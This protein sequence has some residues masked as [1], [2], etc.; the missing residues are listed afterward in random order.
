MRILNTVLFCALS[1]VSVPDAL[2]E[3]E[4]SDTAQEDGSFHPARIGLCGGYDPGCYGFGV[5]LEVSG[6]YF[7]TNVH[8]GL[9]WA[10]I[11]CKIYPGLS[12]HSE[13]LSLR[14]YVG[15]G[16]AGSED[17]FIGWLTGPSVG[18]D[19][20]LLKNKRLL[21][22]PQLSWTKEGHYNKGWFPSGSLSLMWASS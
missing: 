13:A 1:A 18:V 15:Y 4:P 19:L 17:D 6:K 9:L 2:A 3:D 8:L 12:V 10:G 21:L 5:K 14:P 20:H 7:G 16:I 22:Q 11:Q